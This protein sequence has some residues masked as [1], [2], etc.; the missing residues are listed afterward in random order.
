MIRSNNLKVVEKLKI[1][2]LY[3]KG[4]IK[5]REYEKMY[6]TLIDDSVDAII[7]LDENKTII[8]ANKAAEKLYGYKK[9]EFIGMS[10]YYLLTEEE[11]KSSEIYFS[12]VIKNSL[13][14][15]AIHKKKNGNK[16]HAEVILN[17]ALLNKK[18]IIMVI[19][20][21]VSERKLIESNLEYM[22][23]YDFLTNIYNR[24]A[25]LV[26]FSSMIQ[27]AKESNN[28]L[29]VLFFDIDKF[30]HINDEYGHATGDVVLID[31]AARIKSIIA[32]E[33]I[34]GRMGGDEFVIIKSCV[35]GNENVI[36]FINEVFDT[37]NKPIE[38]DDK[39][40]MV[41]TSIGVA[42]FPDDAQ[43]RYSL[44]NFSDDA[45]YEAK[46]ISGN[47]Y[48]MYNDIKENS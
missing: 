47:S 23:N 3:A 1:F 5:S 13:T 43:D 19:V 18:S 45:M 37:F 15:E 24:S 39:E 4:L 41:N 9:F 32:K 22:A 11:V 30:K 38:V 8:E 44:I 2:F 21:D 42:I 16:F 10:H 14:F 35:S 28:K 7:F 29:A 17:S 27:W 36:N 12:K 33:D 31:V 26:K 6:R 20:R 48:K 40:I 34:L 46:K 25:L